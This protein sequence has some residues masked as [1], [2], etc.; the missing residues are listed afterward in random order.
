MADTFWDTP[1]G[2]TMAEPGAGGNFL[3][4]AEKDALISSGMPFPVKN[5]VLMPETNFGPQFFLYIDL[6]DPATG[7]EEERIL[8]FGTGTVESRD[9]QITA[10]SEYFENGGKPF[11]CK[12]TKIGRSQIITK[13]E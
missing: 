11:D 3:N 8:A 4:G 7:D 10:M 5:A 13:A 9:R 6:Q 12:L 2:K 1:V